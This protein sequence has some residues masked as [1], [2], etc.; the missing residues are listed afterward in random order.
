MIRLQKKMME[1]NSKKLFSFNYVHI[2]RN[3]KNHIYIATK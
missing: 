2:L 3:K 1:K